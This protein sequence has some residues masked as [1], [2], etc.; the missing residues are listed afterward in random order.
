MARLEDTQPAIA[1]LLLRWDAY[2]AGETTIEEIDHLINYVAL[3]ASVEKFGMQYETVEYKPLEHYLINN[4]EVQA[5]VIHTAG[6]R[7]IRED[8]SHRVLIRALVTT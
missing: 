6:A 5:V 2:K 7:A 1:S 3:K 8:G 4:V